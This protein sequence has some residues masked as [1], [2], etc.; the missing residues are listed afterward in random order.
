MIKQWKLTTIKQQQPKKKEKKL[1]K[2]ERKIDGVEVLKI[3]KLI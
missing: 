1:M 3:R 2:N